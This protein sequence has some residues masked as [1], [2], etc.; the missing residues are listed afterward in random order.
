MNKLINFDGLG[1]AIVNLTN[2][3]SD[4]IGCI[5]NKKIPKKIAVNTYIKEIQEQDYDPVT[6]AA[7]INRF[8]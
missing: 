2:K 7:L 6:K 4:G 1:E 5:T 3:L 8:C